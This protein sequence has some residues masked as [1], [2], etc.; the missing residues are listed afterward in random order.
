LGLC[1][2]GYNLREESQHLWRFGA[3][4]NSGYGPFERVAKGGN[5]AVAS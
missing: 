5:F 2:L 1:F 3:F 4:P